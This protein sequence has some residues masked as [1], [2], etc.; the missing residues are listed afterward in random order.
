VDDVPVETVDGPQ[1]HIRRR[2]HGFFHHIQGGMQDE[3]VQLRVAFLRGRD[4]RTGGEE[5][6]KG[7][8]EGGR[9]GGWQE[10]LD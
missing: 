5:R 1:I 10:R 4:L 8:R 2:P 3:L 7:G 9:E 6:R